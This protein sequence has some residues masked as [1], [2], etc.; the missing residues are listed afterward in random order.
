[1]RTKSYTEL[2]SI[3]LSEIT[4]AFK[5]HKA[6]FRPEKRSVKKGYYHE[7]I[8]QSLLNNEKGYHNKNNYCDISSVRPISWVIYHGHDQITVYNRSNYEGEMHYL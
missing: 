3:F 6:T 4:N 8:I 7:S 5:I 2:H 1:M